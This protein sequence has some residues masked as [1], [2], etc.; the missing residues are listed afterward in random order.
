M[1]GV[2]PAETTFG[3]GAL[4]MRVDHLKSWLVAVIREERPDTSN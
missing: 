3:G 1:G 4:G 2:T